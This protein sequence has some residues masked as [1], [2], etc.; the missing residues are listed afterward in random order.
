MVSDIKMELGEKPRLWRCELFQYEKKKDV[1]L[2]WRLR[3][4][5]TFIIIINF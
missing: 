3:N 4:N 5:M 2:R 1:V